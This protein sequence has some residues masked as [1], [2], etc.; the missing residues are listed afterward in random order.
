MS[1]KARSVEENAKDKEH[2]QTLL[3]RLQ[4]ADWDLLLIGDG[5]GSGWAT[6]NGWAATLIERQTR[7]RRLFYGAMNCGSNNLAEAMPYLQAMIWYNQNRSQGQLSS[8][9]RVTIITD[10]DVIAIHGTKTA[11]LNQPIPRH[12]S[13]IWAA[14]RELMRNGYQ[15]TFRWSRR[16]SSDLNRV[17]DAI[18]GLA[19]RSV[20]G[21]NVW[22]ETF[23]QTV[24]DRASDAIGK[25]TFDVP[26]DLSDDPYKI[27]PL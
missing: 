20:V 11:D 26:P 12:F 14:F 17:A 22:D 24:A 27:N 6:A 10:S 5:S 13:P 21:Q 7:L 23:T 18:A 8:V 15:F 9:T 4:I 3:D 16:E 1:R 2:L 19:R 25:M